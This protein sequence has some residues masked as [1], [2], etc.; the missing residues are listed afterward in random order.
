MVCSSL[1]HL[2]HP[3]MGR[4]GKQ[5]QEKGPNKH[6]H[7]QA[8]GRNDWVFGVLINVQRN[9]IYSVL[10]RDVTNPEPKV[11]PTFSADSRRPQ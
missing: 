6:Q 2:P 7:N 5:H 3:G 11:E 9:K 4:A 1:S 10:G 8:G